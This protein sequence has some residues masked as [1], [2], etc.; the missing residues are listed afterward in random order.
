[1]R[2]QSR[3]PTHLRP[4]SHEVGGFPKLIE[5]CSDDGGEDQGAEEAAW[6][7]PRENRFVGLESRLPC[8]RLSFQS[9]EGRC[10]LCFLHL[11]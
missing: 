6:G 11:R 7:V 1:V 4:E 2:S 10:M 5:R 9:D 8:E 3:A